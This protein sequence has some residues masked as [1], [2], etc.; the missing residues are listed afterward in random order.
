MNAKDA[1]E[2]ESERDLTVLARRDGEREVRWLFQYRNW[3]VTLPYNTPHH[4]CVNGV[5]FFVFCFERLLLSD[6]PSKG[7]VLMWSRNA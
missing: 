1:T 6:V 2:R 5:L 4:Q 3:H 7:G